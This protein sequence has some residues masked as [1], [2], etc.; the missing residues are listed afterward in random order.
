MD[1]L[2]AI[3]F[4]ALSKPQVDIIIQP[5]ESLW[6]YSHAGSPSTDEYLR[7][8]GVSGQATPE[9]NGGGDDWSYG[10]LKF[11]VGSARA[12]APSK[13]LL[14][15]YNVNP[16]GYGDAA[17]AAANPLQARALVGGFSGKDWDYSLAVKVHPGLASTVFGTG[18]L[19]AVTDAKAPIPITVDLLKGPGDFKAYWAAA[20]GGEGHT[21]YLALTS[22]IAPS[23]EEGS[24]GK[25]G[26]YKVFSAAAKEIKYRP[27][28]TLVY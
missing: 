23:T 22:P 4:L 1:M 11:D 3:A 10:Y 8:W 18:T 27:S 14:T 24:S 13:A 15:L 28:L 25:G 9:G 17:T 16:P 12:E 19:G 26:V 6:V 2:A 7:V 5:A 20:R 21:L